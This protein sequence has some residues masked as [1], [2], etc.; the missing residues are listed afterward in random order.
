MT[1]KKKVKAV[2]CDI[3]KAL[4]RVWHADSYTNLMQLVLQERFVSGSKV[5]YLTVEAS[6]S[7]RCI[8]CLELYQ[9]RGALW[10]FLGPLLFL[11]FINDIVIC[12]ASYL[13]L[14]ADDTN[15]FI[16]EQMPLIL[17]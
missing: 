3:S 17:N 13:R 5:F 7:L 15:F 6:G 10:S 11:L 2:F 9:S 4:F 16:I 12:I 14:F 8:F 1:Q